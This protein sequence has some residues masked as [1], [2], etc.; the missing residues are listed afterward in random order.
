M[1]ESTEIVLLTEEEKKNK[2]REQDRLR[3]AKYYSEK[4]D[5]I[6]ERR[7]AKYQEKKVVVV[8]V[9]E[10]TLPS[11]DIILQTLLEKEFASE[12]T[13]K[14]YVNDIKRLIKLAK[15]IS[16][17]DLIKEHK[18]KDLLESSTFSSST[19]K[20]MVFSV[21]QIIKDYDLKVEVEDL[22]LYVNTLIIVINDE[23]NKKKAEE[24]VLSFKDY[25]EKVKEKYGEDS[26]IYT[27]GCIYQEVTLRDDF[28][29]ILTEQPVEEL[30]KK[31]ENYLFWVGQTMI[32]VINQ[33]K[34]EKTYGVIVVELSD[35]LRERIAKYIT[36]NDI[37]ENKYVFGDKPLSSYICKKNKEIGIDGGVS[38]YRRMK[39]S[40]LKND[41]NTTPEDLAIL[42]KSM[43]HSP[44]LQIQYMRDQKQLEV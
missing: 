18:I 3:Q 8:K 17:F 4:K 14:R 27:L 16:I 36:K 39:I 21:Y 37:D 40:D 44:L 7:K 12:S 42:A 6:N 22:E 34:T 1:I 15:D 5:K 41:I 33:Y 20:G 32:V 19:K 43:K 28:Q 23:L 9:E 35:E 10:P 11:N 38:L 26:K 2:K 24:V 30:K 29:L 13:K 31:N 25:L